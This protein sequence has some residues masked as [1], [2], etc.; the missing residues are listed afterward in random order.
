MIY[1]GDILAYGEVEGVVK[2][3]KDP[4]ELLEFKEGSILVA[5]Q[6]TPL[7]N[8]FLFK[9][10]AV[11]VEHG[12][13]LCHAAIVSRELGI[14]CIRVKGATKIFKDGQKVRIDPEKEIVEVVE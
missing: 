4:K 10:K 3:V 6:P 1:E 8:P 2:V 12:G 5:S 14:P 7:F 11:I 9:S 13:M